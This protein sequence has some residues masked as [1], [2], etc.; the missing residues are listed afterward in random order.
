[1]IDLL[2]LGDFGKTISSIVRWPILLALVTIGLALLYRYA[3]SRRGPQWRWVSWG[4]ATATV[5][6]L[7]GSALFSLYVAKFAGYDKSY[8]A[9]GGVVVLLMWLYVSA[10]VVISG[11]ELN[12]EIEHQ[13]ARDTTIPGGKPFGAR[14]A[15]MADSIGRR[16]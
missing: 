14:G 8:G 11:A 10:F 16:R 1:V 4:A 2:P 15:K 13:A 3:P 7:V 9:L 6:W 5:L 12:A